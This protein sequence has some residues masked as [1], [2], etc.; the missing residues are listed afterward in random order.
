[1]LKSTRHATTAILRLMA[2]AVL[3][4]LAACTGIDP[5][6]L[7]ADAPASPA[8]TQ[9][10][11][12]R[13]AGPVE[14]GP[15]SWYGPGHHGHRTASGETFDMNALSAAHPTLPFGTEVLVTNLDNGRSVKVR[16]N[17]RGP[18][19]SGFIVDLSAKAAALLG[20]RER[21]IGTVSLRPLT[22]GPGDA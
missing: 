16:V 10:A 13:P 5:A 2:P 11:A 18:H 7:R 4:L 20:L 14:T 3:A 15:A 19:R 8:A 17:D 6:A 21:G 22:R 12:V 9:A 1:M